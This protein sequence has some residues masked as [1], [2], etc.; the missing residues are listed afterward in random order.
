MNL[1]NIYNYKHYKRY[2]ILPVLLLLV[3]LYF[4]P[5]IQLDESLRGGTTIQMQANSSLS[6][7][8][9]TSM[10][11]SHIAGAEASVTEAPGSISVTISANQS[12]T[13]AHNYLI[14]LYSLNDSYSSQNLLIQQLTLATKSLPNATQQGEISASQ[15]NLT[16]ISSEMNTDLAQELAAL[17]PFT[18]N[19]SYPAT[20][21]PGGMLSTGIKAYNYSSNMYQNGIMSYLHEIISFK[22]YSFESVTATLGAFFLLQLRNIILLSFVVVAIAVFFVFRTPVPCLTVVFGS[23]NDIIVALGVMGALGI[24]LGVASVGGLLMLI[25]YSMDTDILAA[26]RILKRSE[27]TPQERAYESFKTGITLTAAAIIT[28]S[29]LLVISYVV[30]I[31]TYF[32]I[33]SIVLAGLVADLITTWMSN[34]PLLLWYKE[35]KDRAKS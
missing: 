10:I 16:K 25:G 21:T 24:P 34:T 15:A 19:Q 4:I 7:L 27:S 14:D 30:Y 12:L 26:I 22:V 31:P 5:H 6:T 23:A 2:I 11:N 9:L 20:A 33:S 29:I 8:Q 18:I 13:N 1:P 28:F 17:K 3:S 35:N 32:E